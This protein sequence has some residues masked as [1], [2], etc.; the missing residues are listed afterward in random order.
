MGLFSR[1]KKDEDKKERKRLANSFEG[2]PH[3]LAIK[4]KERYV[5]KSDYFEIDNYVACIMNFFHREGATDNFGPFYGINKIPAGL[6]DGVTTINLEQV[7]RMGEKWISDRQTQAEK[8]SE[9]NEG[10]QEQTGS[11]KAKHLARSAQDDLEVIAR[12]L[13]D[14]ASYLYVQSR[15]MVKA[16]SLELLDVSIDKITRLFMDRFAT[17]WTAPYT[18]NQRRELTDFTRFNNAKYGKGLYLT[19]VEYAGSHSLVTHGLEDAGGEY[20]GDMVGDVNN[21]AVFFDVNKYRHHIVVASEQINESRGRVNVSDMWASKIGQSAMLNNNR[22]VHLVMDGAELDKLG[23]KFESITS[24]IDLNKGDVNMFEMFGSHERELDIYPAHMQKLILMAE[25]AYET[26]ESDRSVIRGSLED[27]ATKFYV[28]QGMW[29]M[30][31]GANRDKLRIVG[32]PH[33]EVPRLQTF[34]AY[35][36]MEYKAIVNQEARDEE[37]VHALSILSTTFKNLLSSNGDLFN[38]ITSDAIDDAI[39]SNRVIYDFSRLMMRGKGVAMAQLVNI[40][41]FAIGTLRRGDVLVIHGAEHIDEGVRDYI[42]SQLDFLYKNG[43]RVAFCYSNIEKMLND[44]DFNTFDKADYTILGNMSDNTVVRYQKVLGQKI[45]PDLA[46][47]I[48]NK[49]A[50]VCYIRRG[51]DNVVFRQNLQLEPLDDTNKGKSR[52]TRRRQLLGGVN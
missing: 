42:N 37:K 27:V 22:V 40:I 13:N 7:S 11:N 45:P 44:Q 18:G 15:L 28:D 16:P 21:S 34:S 8:I 23:P 20:V 5:F 19:S 10:A 4:P 29:H 48:A 41:G 51:F 24:L 52:F 6:P 3:L 2:Y 35:L 49:S 30:N 43:G 9:A 17:L 36:D 39:K 25:Q 14:G 33:D 26:T 31:A 32:I 47:L 50:G 1:F 46:N 12:E 38:T